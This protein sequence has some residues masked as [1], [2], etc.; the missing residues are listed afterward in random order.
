VIAMIWRAAWLLL[1]LA[2]ALHRFV[3]S[4]PLTF[5]V[6]CASLVPLAKSMG[7]AT[8]S[9][10]ERMGPLPGSLL[11]ATFGN[12]AELILAIAALLHGHIQLVKGSLTGSI[13][14]NLLLVAGASIVVGGV[15][16]SRLRFNRLAASSSVATLF[17]AVV[18]M[19][20][21]T[22]LSTSARDFNPRLLS[23]EISVV[24]IAMY[25]LSLWFG[26]RTHAREMGPSRQPMHATPAEA[27]AAEGRA[28]GEIPREPI[29]RAL[30]LLGL[31]AVGTAIAS[32]VLLAALDGALR[33]LHLPETFAGVIIVAIVGNA[34]E[35]ST[36]V[37][38]A[39]RGEMDVALGIAWESSK[40]IAL[41]VAPVLVFLGLFIGAPMDLAFTRFEVI[42]LG[43]AVLA[44]SLIAL[45][46][47]THWLEGAFL[48]GVYAVLGMGFFFIG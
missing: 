37:L 21:P 32:E 45:D 17:L 23:V 28:A 26:L 29:W 44:L 12:A 41:F 43:L 9:L 11:N 3:H 22:L 10:A 24:L 46:G 5:L 25:A 31:A 38:F 19:V 48:L 7:G 18:A 35:H 6:A 4:D 2:W 47:E 15:R 16:F 34:A 36:A 30:V 33:D 27:A 42:A 13:L 20:V 8:D 14:G 39:R 40:Q 1:P